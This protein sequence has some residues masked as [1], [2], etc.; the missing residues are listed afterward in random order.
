MVT[1]HSKKKQSPFTYNI[2]KENYNKKHL[3]L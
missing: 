2:N 3:F 1:A